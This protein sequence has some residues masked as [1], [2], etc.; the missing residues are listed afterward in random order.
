MPGSR[1]AREDVTHIFPNFDPFQKLHL[2]FF[3]R[4]YQNPKIIFLLSSFRGRKIILSSI[5]SAGKICF[6]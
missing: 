3:N 1:S 2:I 4:F 5:F 6:N